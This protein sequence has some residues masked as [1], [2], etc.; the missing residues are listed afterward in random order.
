MYNLHN[1]RWRIVR[2]KAT[3]EQGMGKKVIPLAF[4]SQSETF[5]D[6]QFSEQNR[7]LKCMAV[8]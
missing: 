4:D 6:A 2:M 7:T 8:L 1:V 3:F 5:G